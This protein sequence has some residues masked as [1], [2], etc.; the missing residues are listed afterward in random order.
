LQAPS[1]RPLPLKI[2]ET[3]IDRLAL[4]RALQT[5]RVLAR[6]GPGNIAA[7]FF[8]VQANGAGAV[9]TA[10]AGATYCQITL[11][12]TIGAGGAG[13]CAV[14]RALRLLSFSEG[15]AVTL[16]ADDGASQVGFTCGATRAR[17]PAFPQSELPQRAPFNP[18]AEFTLNGAAFAR[19][20]ARAADAWLGA[21]EGSGQYPGLHIAGNG[22]EVTV[23]ATDG[24]ALHRVAFPCAARA[25]CMV[26]PA[27]VQLVASVEAPQDFRIGLSENAVRLAA[28]GT[29]F[30][31]QLLQAAFPDTSGVIPA[32]SANSIALPCAP[33]TRAVQL[34]RAV[35][36]PDGIACLRVQSARNYTTLSAVGSAG[37]EAR[38]ILEAPNA[39]ELDFKV[40]P[41]R[42]LAAIKQIAA[43]ELV[44]IQCD[45]PGNAVVIRDGDFTAFI[46]TLRGPP[47]PAAAAA[48]L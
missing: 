34:C 38:E 31:C 22:A 40:D 27:V 1:A 44:V 2:M 45:P 10:D 21:P 4:L 6:P 46:A 8:N 17:L 16:A 39:A 20:V 23:Q 18:K 9:L 11:P 13:A 28:G 3:K 14:D 19:A 26:A 33:L 15:K 12:A 25:D 24:R 42:L 36:D 29:V 30:Q 37:G 35:M 32:A 7:Q 47:K 48:D 5:L 43:P 41:A